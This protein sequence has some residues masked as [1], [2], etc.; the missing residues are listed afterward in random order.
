MV[1]SLA[2]CG[3]MR[4]MA[5]DFSKPSAPRATPRNSSAMP[6]MASGPHQTVAGLVHAF[7]HEGQPWGWV[8]SR[9][10]FQG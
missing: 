3:S 8:M 5:T 2:R 1:G 10:S 7:L 9:S 4:L 6:P